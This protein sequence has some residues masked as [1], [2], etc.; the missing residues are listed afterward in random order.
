MN[1]LSIF[2]LTAVTALVCSLTNP[3]QSKA[4]ETVPEPTP[5]A[6]TQEVIDPT[7]TFEDTLFALINEERAR[8]GLNAYILDETIDA[9]SE[10]RI[11]ELEEVFSH[12]RDGGKR[13][14]TIL[15]DFGIS[16]TSASEIIAAGQTSPELVL[17]AWLNSPR[18]GARILSS[19]YVK[20]GVAHNR[21]VDGTDYWEVLFIN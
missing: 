5:E 17:Q 3:I 18:H 8:H 19:E 20:I 7:E 2:A 16:Y 14:S 10:I 13:F 11:F 15:S 4:A 12:N 21:A 9:A 1:S 6:Y